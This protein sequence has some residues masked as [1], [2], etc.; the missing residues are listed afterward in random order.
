MSSMS[1]DP[2]GAIPEGMRWCPHC[3][4]Y[5]S[6]LKEASGRCS[7]CGGSGLVWQERERPVASRNGEAPR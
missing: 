3:D 4:G 2:F 6:S 7:H 1:Q 5:G